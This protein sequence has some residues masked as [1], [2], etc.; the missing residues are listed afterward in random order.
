MAGRLR[1]AGKS[2]KGL[3]VKLVH[4]FGINDAPYKTH[5][6]S[7]I[8]GKSVTTWRCPYYKVWASMIER[9]YSSNFHSRHR[10]Y[11]DYSV[12][13]EWVY[14]S[15]FKAWMDGQDWE[16]K[17]L[18]KD[19][20]IKGNRLYSPETCVFVSAGLNSFFLDSAASRGKWPV[21]VSVDSL[22]GRFKA[23]CKDP[24]TR[25]TI[26]LGR[27]NRATDAHEAWRKK[28]HELACKYAESEKDERVAT[29]LRVRFLKPE[30]NEVEK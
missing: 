4:G 19:I 16:E 5:H 13:D 10:T 9:A 7:Y 14:F 24:F 17:E 27:F 11:S 12:C 1:F 22:T 18:D 29:A 30:S 25:K 6:R 20:L 8:L 28:K 2:K 3:T 21:G 23:Q 15:A 26:H